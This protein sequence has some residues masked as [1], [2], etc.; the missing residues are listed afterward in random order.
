[1]NQ[2][3]HSPQKDLHAA[4]SDLHTALRARWNNDAQLR[5]E[6]RDNF[7]D[8]AAFEEGVALGKIKG[9]VTRS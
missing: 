7:E 2:A 8:Y 9:A 4:R 5:A 3:Q 6:F 1:M